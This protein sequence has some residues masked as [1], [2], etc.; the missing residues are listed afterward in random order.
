MANEKIHYTV[1]GKSYSV[2]TKVWS[3]TY[4]PATTDATPYIVFKN[5]G[6]AVPNYFIPVEFT[7]NAPYVL[8]TSKSIIPL[9]FTTSVIKFLPGVP[10]AVYEFSTPFIV[11]FDP[12]DLLL[13]ATPW[14]AKY[15]SKIAPYARTD[16]YKLR[17]DGAVGNNKQ[18]VGQ[19]SLQNWQDIEFHS[20]DFVP[21]NPALFTF[22]D[23]QYWY[24][25][26]KI[27][28]TPATSVPTAQ[29]G[30]WLIYSNTAGDTLIR[31][32]TLL[33]LQLD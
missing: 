29:T 13:P 25:N 23:T 31:T 27:L 19:I 16:E 12:R 6:Q 9:H 18:F 11:N 7:Q 1:D 15:A 26:Y 33:Y 2:Y 20:N 8:E 32:A 10:A 22:T 21:P 4:V 3:D 24:L 28:N 30:G 5:P 17:F 14:N